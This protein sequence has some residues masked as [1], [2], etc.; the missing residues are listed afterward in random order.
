MSSHDVPPE[1]LDDW[2]RA[3]NDV[4]RVLRRGR[5]RVGV[6]GEGETLTESQVAVLDSVAQR[7]ALPVG[8]IARQAGIAQPTVTRMLNSLEERGIVSRRPSDHDDRV[9][10]VELTTRGAELW[11]GKRRILRDFQKDSLL[12]FPP[13]TRRQVVAV[14]QDFV[15]IVDAQISTK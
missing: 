15:Q 6:L 14:L 1:L 4:Y 11:E 7:G 8:E 2:I 5:S 9:T 13:E 3:C 12:Q 10:L